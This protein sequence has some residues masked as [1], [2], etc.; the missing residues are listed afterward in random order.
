ME[1]ALDGLG[2]SKPR[3]TV[4]QLQAVMQQSTITIIPRLIQDLESDKTNLHVPA[5]REL[6]NIVVD[7]QNSKDLTLKY[8]LIPLMNKFSENI[9]KNDEFVLSTTIQHVIG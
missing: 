3:G 6:L 2:S 5:L 1:A 8:K 9:E 4:S 7:N